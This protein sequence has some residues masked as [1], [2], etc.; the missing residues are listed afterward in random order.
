M[1]THNLLLPKLTDISLVAN[2]ILQK[3]KAERVKWKKSNWPR[4]LVHQQSS[5]QWTGTRDFYARHC[6]RWI[7]WVSR[8]VLSPTFLEGMISS[9]SKNGTRKFQLMTSISGSNSGTIGGCSLSK[10][11]AYQWKL[12][13]LFSAL[14]IWMVCLCFLFSCCLFPRYVMEEGGQEKRRGQERGKSLL[15]RE[16]SR[17]YSLS[18]GWDS[19]WFYL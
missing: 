17:I 18:A 7:T 12:N 3:T 5:H 16:M 10:V 13:S 19:M 4:S 15:F 8:F 2:C 11:A 6:A 9:C 1:N 14:C